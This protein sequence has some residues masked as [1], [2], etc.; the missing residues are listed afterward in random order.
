MKR[1]TI[2]ILYV[3]HPCIRGECEGQNEEKKISNRSLC[4]AVMFCG[5]RM[6]K[7]NERAKNR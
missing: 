1:W 6:W 4:N 3:V 2:Y 5:S 7:N